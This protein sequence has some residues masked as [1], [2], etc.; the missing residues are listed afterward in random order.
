VAQTFSVTAGWISMSI[1][2]GG[3]MGDAAGA[4][5]DLRSN[6]KIR[7]PQSVEIESG[8][9]ELKVTPSNAITQA[10]VVE[11]KDE[12]GASTKMENGSLVVDAPR[13]IT[14]RCGASEVRLSPDGVYIN[15]KLFN[16]NAVNTQIETERFDVSGD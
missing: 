4:S 5:L 7:A 11:Q 9:S 13:G 10:R 3:G 14:F 6:A 12:G 1:G 8:A 15:G 2:G 16:V